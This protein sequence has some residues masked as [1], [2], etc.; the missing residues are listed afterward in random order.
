MQAT[1]TGAVSAAVGATD[2]MLPRVDQLWSS[3]WFRMVTR[4]F[5]E[6]NGFMSLQISLHTD[7]D[8]YLESTGPFNSFLWRGTH[9][10]HH[11]LFKPLHRPQFERCH[12]S[13]FV[14]SYI[15][16]IGSLS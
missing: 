10:C 15:F 12:S 3:P 6:Q 5:D 2:P 4:C 16:I 9:A 8:R 11:S 14:S 13:S 1:H 7:I